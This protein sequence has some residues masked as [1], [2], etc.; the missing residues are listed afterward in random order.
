MSNQSI[1]FKDGQQAKVSNRDAP[2]TSAVA[3]AL[4]EEQYQ[5]AMEECDSSKQF[6]S[7]LYFGVRCHERLTRISLETPTMEEHDWLEH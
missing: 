6:I 1:A 3:A 4:L 7:P 5:N 2:Q